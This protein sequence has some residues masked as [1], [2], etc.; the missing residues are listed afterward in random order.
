MR[1]ERRRAGRI[2]PERPFRRSDCE[3]LQRRP[4]ARNQ[5]WA[6]A[7]TRPQ[8]VLNFAV[9]ISAAITAALGALQTV[10]GHGVLY[11]GLINLGIA[12]VFLAIPLLNRFGTVIPAIVFVIIAYSSLTF[13]GS[14][15]GTDSGVQFYYLVSAS[16]AV[17]VL[18]IEHLKLAGAVVAVGA[19][20]VV[21]M[22]F[23]VPADTGI[24]PRW[25]VIA[26]FMIATA[27]AC[28]LIFTTVWYAMREV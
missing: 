8:R 24:Q 6:D 22:Q 19:A 21:G 10:T 18:C 4:P 17:L 13:V 7:V 14:Q 2:L 11:I 9:W 16:L 5:H 12:G 28:T 25:A 15:I 20:L 3:R 26:G 23:L 27:G 1:S